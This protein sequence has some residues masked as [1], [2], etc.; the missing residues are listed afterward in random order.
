MWH[1][2]WLLVA[3]SKILSSRH[4]IFAL[5]LEAQP[6]APLALRSLAF[7]WSKIIFWWITVLV[8]A[9]GTALGSRC[10]IRPLA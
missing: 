6:C 4:S 10:T 5:E 8:V 1:H 7:W 3:P 9:P 2:T